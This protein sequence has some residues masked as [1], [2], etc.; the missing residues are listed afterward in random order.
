MCTYMLENARKENIKKNAP[1]S[2]ISS[3]FRKAAMQ[4]KNQEKEFLDRGRLIII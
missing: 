2:L 4:T 1:T 3:I